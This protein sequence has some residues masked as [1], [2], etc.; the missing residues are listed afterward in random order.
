MRRTLVKLTLYTLL[1]WAAI[2]LSKCGPGPDQPGKPQF[3]VDCP[4]SRVI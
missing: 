4:S 3:S 1:I 2:S